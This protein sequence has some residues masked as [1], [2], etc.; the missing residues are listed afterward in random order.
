VILLPAQTTYFGALCMVGFGGGWVGVYDC[1][2]CL[3]PE[4]TNPYLLICRL[5]KGIVPTS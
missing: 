3:S 2:I 1:T 5:A 4:R